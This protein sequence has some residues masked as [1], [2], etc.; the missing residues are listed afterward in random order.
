MPSFVCTKVHPVCQY[1]EFSTTNMY[2]TPAICKKSSGSKFEKFE[3]KRG[4]AGED[5]LEI[6]VKY[7]GFCHTDTHLANNDWG[8][9]SYPIVPGHEVAG[10]VAKVSIFGDLLLSLATILALQM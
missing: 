8:S 6:D 3:V 10:V 4:C 7:C 1:F 2:S 5:D 9:T